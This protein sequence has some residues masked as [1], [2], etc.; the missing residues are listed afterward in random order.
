M[1]DPN[2]APFIDSA[3]ERFLAAVVRVFGG[4]RA[5]S[6]VARVDA[7][8]GAVAAELARRARR[9]RARFDL[10]LREAPPAHGA[11]L[12][13]AIKA[14]QGSESALV[15]IRR[16]L[17]P[18]VLKRIYAYGLGW[19]EADLV[20][21]V[22]A[23][24][25]DKLATYRGQSSLR[26][27]GATVSA[28]ALKNWMRAADAKP[29]HVPLETRDGEVRDLEGGWTA[30]GEVMTNERETRL[31]RMARALASVAREVLKPE[32]WELL[33]EQIVEGRSYAELTVATGRSEVA[34][35]K[36][37]FDALKR[38]RRAVFERYGD[39]FADDVH[40]ALPRT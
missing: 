24:L 2:A 23:R 15:E 38:L 11:D 4:L 10:F 40:E 16:R 32:D 6:A 8:L 12:A 26:T 19:N 5:A 37:R 27:W 7:R 35:R 22:F 13:L 17:E 14:Q 34:L 29:E 20:E 36:R 18:V 9:R 39:R 25:W 31:K 1:S 30:D 3:D 28:N 21:L 33:Q